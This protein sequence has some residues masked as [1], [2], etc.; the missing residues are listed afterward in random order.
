MP[1]TSQDTDKKLSPDEAIG[2]S[3]HPPTQQV[4]LLVR[5]RVLE[6][7]QKTLGSA[8]PTAHDSF[9]MTEQII[10]DILNWISQCY[11]LNPSDAVAVAISMCAGKVTLHLC[12]SDAESAL[13]T[14]KQLISTLRTVLDPDDNPDTSS[15]IGPFFRL[16]VKLS[17][18]RILHKLSR[19]GTT[20]EDTDSTAR[21]FT[22]LVAA[23]LLFRPEGELSRGFVKV[24]TNYGG[25]TTD[26]MIQSFI[27]VVVQHNADAQWRGVTE[28][29]CF[30]YISSIITACT[31]LINSTFFSDVRNSRS[32]RSYLRIEDRIFL[33]KIFRRLAYIASY[34]TG[35]A[36]F[37]FLGVPFLRQILGREGVKHF[38]GGE[39]A[40]IRIDLAFCGLGSA[41]PAALSRQTYQWPSESPIDY[42]PHIIN[43]SNDHL[44][45]PSPPPSPC[46]SRQTS[47]AS[48]NSTGSGSTDASIRARSILARLDNELR[49]EL[50]HSEVISRAWT[51]GIAISVQCH[52]ELQLVHYLD[53]HRIAVAYRVLGTN[54]RPCWACSRYLDCLVVDTGL[55]EDREGGTA[56]HTSQTFNPNGWKFHELL[57]RY[58]P[59]VRLK[60][61]LGKRM[62]YTFD[63]K[64]MHH[65]LVK[66]ASLFVPLRVEPMS[67]VFGKSLLSTIGDHH[68]KQ[69]KMLNPVFSI[70]HMRSMMPIFY[71]VADQLDTA[72]SRRVKDGP[73]EIDL[74]GWITRAA[75]ELIG[76]SG[77]GYSFDNM[78]DDLP[79][80][81]YS[82]YIK[83]LA[84]TMLKI[85]FIGINMVSLALRFRIPV[86][87]RTFLMNITPWKALH[88]VRDMVNYM[89]DVSIEIYKEK[90]RELEET[91]ETVKEVKKDLLSILMRDNEEAGREDKLEEAEVIA[92]VCLHSV[93]FGCVVFYHSVDVN[94]HIRRNGHYFDVQDELRREIQ[95]AQLA[96]QGEKLSYDELVSL[97]LLDAV[98]RETLRLYPPVSFLGRNTA[99]EVVVPLSNPVHGV[100]GAEISEVFIPKGTAV[101]VSIFNANRSTALWGPDAV[102]WKPERWLSTLPESIANSKIPGIYS[103][104]MT[105]GAGSHS[106]IGFKFS[107]LEMKVMVAMLVQRFKFSLSPNKV[108]FWEMSGIASPVIVGGDGHRQLPLMVELAGN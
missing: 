13:R 6:Q 20:D 89:H 46:H 65:I 75:L 1:C 57:G 101:L 104:L 42:L 50:L 72:L 11:A 33:L 52:P 17:H 106:C 39:E 4:D 19:I 55:G 47:G 21:R 54:K 99:Q 32:F 103:H 88:D 51:P 44:N 83:S 107:Q 34:K 53:H 18:R 23:W 63:S 102:E 36:K 79:K 91:D 69:R 8:P 78:E 25:T 82:L 43:L 58:G 14:S 108:I 40:G 49:Y 80:H 35:A 87:V 71:G 26:Y 12:L 2:H 77:F 85:G 67:L 62:F 59:A 38:V 28:E 92:Q 105:F 66:D 90:K 96:N 16:A 60:A 30:S 10:L 7:L 9:S 3:D 48:I 98:S 31:L 27:T 56:G 95:E 15:A 73:R 22:S 64:A 5:L 61:F 97:P 81:K 100:N 84:P 94:L 70:A 37:A 93:Y 29:Q 41:R 24:A 45:S 68:R 86:S 76:R 74:L